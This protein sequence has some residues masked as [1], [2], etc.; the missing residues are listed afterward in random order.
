MC[1]DGR[2]DVSLD[3]FQSNLEALEWYQRL[4]FERTARTT[5]TEYAIPPERHSHADLAVRQDGYGFAQLFLRGEHVG[6][7]IASRAVVSSHLH[8]SYVGADVARRVVVRTRDARGEAGVTL[9]VSI[10]MKAKVS[11]VLKGLH[12]VAR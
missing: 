9:D 2:R 6:T 4:G 10:H 7:K 8:V 5:W 3:V 12:D 1:C 11:D